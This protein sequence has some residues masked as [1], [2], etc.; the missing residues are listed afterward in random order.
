M[1]VRFTEHSSVPLLKTVVPA[2]RVRKRWGIPRGKREVAVQAMGRSFFCAAPTHHTGL[3]R[4]KTACV[5]NGPSP[6][7]ESEAHRFHGVT[8]GPLFGAPQK[9]PPMA[10][11]TG[12]QL[13][14]AIKHFAMP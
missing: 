7:D 2:R 9:K 4:V 5:V 12:V 3:T 1:H 11:S 6:K 14:T 8:D 13:P 10:W